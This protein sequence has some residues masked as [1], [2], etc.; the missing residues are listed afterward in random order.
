MAVFP[1]FEDDSLEDFVPDDDLDQ[2]EEVQPPL[3]YGTTWLFDFDEGDIYLSNK[4][5]TPL[6]SGMETLK[7][8]IRHTLSIRLFESPIYGTNVG[9]DL[10]TLIGSKN[11]AY[12]ALRLKKEIAEAL[13]SHDRI[14]SAD[15]ETVFKIGHVA[16]AFVAFETDDSE[17]QELLLTLG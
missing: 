11:E 8:W 16:Y 3:A 1:E 4:G 2:D 15:V 7:Q 14:I 9:T 13:L 5:E 17:R 10:H 6:V 12:A